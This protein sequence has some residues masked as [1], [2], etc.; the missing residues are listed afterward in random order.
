V[1]FFAKAAGE[2]KAIANNEN[3]IHDFIGLLGLTMY[4]SD[5]MP[6]AGARLQVFRMIEPLLL[7]PVAALLGAVA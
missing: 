1:A 5:L 6:A 4:L 7:L 2:S 3:A